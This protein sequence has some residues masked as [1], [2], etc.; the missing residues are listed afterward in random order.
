[1]QVVRKSVFHSHGAYGYNKISTL[2]E[3]GAN[4]TSH[5]WHAAEPACRHSHNARAVDCMLIGFIET[6]S[7]AAV[8]AHAQTLQVISGNVNIQ[9]LILENLILVAMTSP[10][11]KSHPRKLVVLIDGDSIEPADFG[12]VFAWAA[13]R[14]EVILRRIYGNR[15]KLSDWSKCI[16]KHGIEPVD[17]YADGGNAADFTM[18]IDAIDILHAQKDINGFCIVAADNHFA[19]VAKRLGKE[20]CFV[21]VLWSLNSNEPKSSFKDGCDVF[22]Y[23]DELPHADDPDPVAHEA[24]SAWKDAVRD[25][26]HKLAPGEGWALLS[27]VGNLLKATGHDFTPLDYCHGKLF[28]LMKSCSEFETRTSPERARLRPR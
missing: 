11:M 1:M 4:G 18:T 2:L 17:N 23:V 21:A 20:K 19:S 8:I 28:S 13:D 14:G 16:D 22:M 10:T 3:N 9:H 12:R 27:D 15:G 7:L 25:A 26:V 5:A 6:D 24:L